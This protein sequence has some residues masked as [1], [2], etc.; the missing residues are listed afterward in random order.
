MPEPVHDPGG[1]HRDRVVVGLAECALDNHTITT[2]LGLLFTSVGAS[3]LDSFT[4]EFEDLRSWSVILIHESTQEELDAGGR[5]ASYGAVELA[6]RDRAET[7]LNSSLT[8]TLILVGCL[9][10]GIASIV[11]KR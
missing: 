8:G 3:C 5:S 11:R 1:D 7:Q 2:Q 9:V 10:L 6:Y 4:V